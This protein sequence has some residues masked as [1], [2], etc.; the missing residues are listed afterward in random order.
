MR[1]AIDA[2][3]KSRCAIVREARIQELPETKPVFKS[4]QEQFAKLSR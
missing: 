1:F 2:S 4:P 3:L